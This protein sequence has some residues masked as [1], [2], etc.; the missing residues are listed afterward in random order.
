MDWFH[1]INWFAVYA[2]RF[3]ERLAAHSV[4]TQGVE[5]FLPMV[6]VE[7]FED[8]VIKVGS[9]PLFPGYFF[10]RF[11]PEVSLV[12]VESSHGV[13]QVV[14]CGRYPIPVN[15]KAVQEIQERVQADGLIRIRR[16]GFKPGDRVSVQS[17]PFE[18]MMARVERELDDEKRVAILLEALS[19]ARVLI[20]KRWVQA[21]A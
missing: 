2:K 20:E 8:V 6:K 11:C 16:Q 1:D 17:G 18:G 10:A 3:R 14:R 9:K 13:L 7:C 12:A 4:G 19:Y 15:D 21:A 5:V